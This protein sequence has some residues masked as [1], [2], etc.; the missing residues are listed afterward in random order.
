MYVWLVFSLVFM[1]S[2]WHL[3]VFFWNSSQTLDGCL[4]PMTT[5]NSLMCHFHVWTAGQSQTALH[6]FDLLTWCCHT[7]LH[8]PSPFPPPCEVKLLVS[9][10]PPPLPTFSKKCVCASFGCHCKVYVF[11]K[12]CIKTS[13]YWLK[14]WPLTFCLANIVWKTKFVYVRYSLVYGQLNCAVS[15]VM[16]WRMWK[17]NCDLWCEDFSVLILFVC[18]IPA[19]HESV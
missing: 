12:T 19:P 2:F 17:R 3:T 6:Y 14:V 13:V 9:P 18:C 1:V 8:C 5:V 16:H 10:R 15:V 11:C 4:Q 7:P